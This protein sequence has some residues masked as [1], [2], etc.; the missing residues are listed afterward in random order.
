[1]KHYFVNGVF[2]NFTWADFFSEDG[3]NVTIGQKENEEP[4]KIEK[5]SDGWYDAEVK[6]FDVETVIIVLALINEC[7]P[8]DITL[9]QRD[10]VAF[11]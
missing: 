7:E 3:P 2:E 1:M 11:L 8:E 6:N 5:D 4:E 10:L 9:E